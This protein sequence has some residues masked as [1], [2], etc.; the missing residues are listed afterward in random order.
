MPPVFARDKDSLP[1]QIFFKMFRSEFLKDFGKPL[2]PDAFSN[3]QTRNQEE[4]EEEIRAATLFLTLQKIPQVAVDLLN[5]FAVHKQ[6]NKPVVNF[7]LTKFLHKSGVNMRYLGLLLEALPE[8]EE[9]YNLVL[10]EIVARIV[11]NRLR[12]QMRKMMTKVKAPAEAPFNMLVIDILN[13]LLCGDRTVTETSKFHWENYIPNQLTPLFNV[14]EQRKIKFS[15]L[16]NKLNKMQFYS[17]TAGKYVLLSRL[18]EMLGLKFSKNVIEELQNNDSVFQLSQVFE[19]TDLEDIGVRVKHMNII[20]SVQVEMS[21]TY[22]LQR[23]ERQVSDEEALR[24]YKKAYEVIEEEMKSNSDLSLLLKC[25]EI[26]NR[27]EKCSYRLNKSRVE[28]SLTN[29]QNLIRARTY[30]LQALNKYPMDTQLLLSYAQFLKFWGNISEAEEYFLRALEIDA[31]LLEGLQHYGKLLL[32]LKS[33]E[34]FGSI[35][36]TRH[37]NIVSQQNL[38]DNLLQKKISASEAAKM[39]KQ[40]EERNNNSVQ[41]FMEKRHFNKQSLRKSKK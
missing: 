8:D 36:M 33:K 2:S 37:S 17:M 28:D 13:S 16:K 35:L 34:S 12:E 25:A 19:Y 7:T 21:L 30:Y 29:N 39:L 40:V 4:D 26:L 3:F 6:H 31:N 24:H 38:I 10:V 18:V 1:G 11:K 20:E 14:S 32:S 5:K 9:L 23:G 41:E 22:A 15:P 27:M